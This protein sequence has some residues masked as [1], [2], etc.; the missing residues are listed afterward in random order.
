MKKSN[1]RVTTALQA[2]AILG[3]GIAASMIVAAPASA[4]DVT[5]G[6]LS[7]T[8]VDAAGKPV[9]G[10]TINI[11]SQS[12]L[13]RGATTSSTG[14]F[15]ITG[16]P[17]GTYDVRIGVPGQPTVLNQA[18]DVQ[19]GGSNYTFETGAANATPSTVG[20]GSEIVVTGRRRAAVDFSGTATGQVF[21]VQEVAQQVPVPRSITGVQLL[22][23]QTTSGD[24]AFGGVSI[25]GSSVAENIYYINGMNVTNFRNGV[26]GTTVP[27]DFYDQV[28]V[29][30][31]G[32]Q[33]EF[34]RNTGG[35]VIALT[36][37]GTN[38]FRGGMNFS[39]SPN[40]TQSDSPNTYAANNSKDI[41]RSAEGNLW[42]SGPIIKDRV[43]FF[44]FFNPRY[45]YTKDTA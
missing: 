26:G 19:L 8:V 34:G 45:S 6:R 12:G 27:F 29:K 25:G 37:S 24:T 30:T 13:Q 10:A 3:A 32:Y 22:A 9:S 31:G 23:P 16:L 28:Q 41:R 40:I 1:L 35:A 14:A 36:R 11:V 17:V 5:A 7:G 44:G 2:L 38:T 15:T 42:A 18:V 39:Y 4:Q 21:N 33:A 20:G 43:F